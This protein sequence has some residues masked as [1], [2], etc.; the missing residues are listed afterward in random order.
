LLLLGGSVDVVLT[1]ASPFPSTSYDIEFGYL[2]LQGSATLSEVSRTAS[3]ITVRVT[4][5]LASVALGSTFFV[6]GKATIAP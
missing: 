4:A 6:H 2:D 5:G 1:W 3:T